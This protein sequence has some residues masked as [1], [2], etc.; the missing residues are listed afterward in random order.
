MFK[1]IALVITALIITSSFGFAQSS[2]VTIGDVNLS[3]LKWGTQTANVTITNNA[4]YMKYLVVDIDFKFTESY[5]NADR[6]IRSTHFIYP[7]VT[8]TIHPQFYVPGNFGKAEV[9]LNIYDVIDTLDVV[10]DYQK[11]YSQPFLIN[12][13]IPDAVFEFSNEKLTLPPRVEL[14]PYYANEFSRLFFLMLNA[15]STYGEQHAKDIL[16]RVREGYDQQGLQAAGHVP[17][18]PK[19]HWQQS[20]VHRL[21]GLV[22]DRM[23]LRTS[24]PMPGSADFV[25]VSLPLDIP[26]FS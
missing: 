15:M 11:I 16:A 12:F 25:E 4:D 19:V 10:M 22:I 20:T 23:E 1:R 17:W 6:K 21:Q 14:H 5:T 24:A 7:G 3:A 13:K 8:K 18:V 2:E 9:T 26:K